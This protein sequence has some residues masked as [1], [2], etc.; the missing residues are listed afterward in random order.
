MVMVIT[1]CYKSKFSQDTILKPSTLALH[2]FFPFMVNWPDL[3]EIIPNFWVKWGDIISCWINGWYVTVISQDMQ[4]KINWC[5]CI[6]KQRRANKKDKT[7][8]RKMI[9]SPF[10]KRHIKSVITSLQSCSLKLCQYVC[11]CT[12]VSVFICWKVQ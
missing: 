9:L 3:H 6:H 8:L 2:L 4:V 1:D 5:N 11:I 12:C 7:N 10:R